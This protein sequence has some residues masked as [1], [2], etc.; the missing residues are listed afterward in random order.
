MSRRIERIDILRGLSILAVIAIHVSATRTVGRPEGAT[1]L[2]AVTINQVS[3][4]AVA[5]FLLMS[6]LG[7]ELRGR[8]EPYLQALW[9]RIVKL[10]PGYLAWGLIY[11]VTTQ[12]VPSVM[13]TVHILITG[14]AAAHM[15]FIPLLTML[16]AL[17][18]PLSAAME[19]WPGSAFVMCIAMV[20]AQLLSRTPPKMQA[21]TNPL[22][23]IG[24]FALGI[25]L[26][27]RLQAFEQVSKRYRALWT[28]TAILSAVFITVEAIVR[29]RA[30][31][32]A[33]EAVTQL[34]PTVLFYTSAIV[35]WGWGCAWPAPI[36]RALASLGRQSF[37]IY[38]SH[39]LVLDQLRRILARLGISR[40]SG[41]FLV[42]G[43]PLVVVGSLVYS[44]VI[45][46][47]VSGVRQRTAKRLSA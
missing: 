33:G 12:K 13:R 16:Y 47:A 7:L 23:W 35:L 20:L 26:A 1:W 29:I 39:I 10:W 22:R 34:R 43:I 3:R 21:T 8:S 11:I 5:V 40:A 44:V 17:Y 38:L 14:K 32:N 27:P 31:V 28:V 9:R 37:N 2:L 19:R 41:T 42:L 15:Y 30:G 24:Y 45:D 36:S 25:W 4:Y 46:Q 18:K 6:G